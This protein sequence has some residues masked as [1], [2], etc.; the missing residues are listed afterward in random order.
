MKFFLLTIIFVINAFATNYVNEFPT[1]V[2][3]DIRPIA[4][5][6]NSI[7]M[8][9]SSDIYQN[10]IYLA[11]LFSTVSI[12]WMVTVGK[13]LVGALKGGSFTIGS[14]AVLLVP[15][16]VHLVDKRLDFGLINNYYQDHTL[17]YEKISHVP[18]LIALTPSIATTIS[19]DLIQLTN[20]A[21]KGNTVTQLS[22][23]E[24]HKFP[25]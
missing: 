9:T 12:G 8:I 3:G 5:I 14:I 1:Y 7:A 13:D 11:I 22:H 21:F 25:I 16:D 18:W 19:T 15:V 17:G 6:Y 10:L 2:Y 20:Q 4:A 24:N 23:I